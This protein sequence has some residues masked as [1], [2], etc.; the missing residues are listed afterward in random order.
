MQSV[1]VVKG[2]PEMDRRWAVNVTGE[3]SGVAR[4]RRTLT[5]TSE[6]PRRNIAF[7]A[8]TG[9]TIS[10]DGEG[11]YRIGEA[12]RIRIDRDH[13]AQII[14]VADGQQLR[15]PLDI[16]AGESTLVIEYEW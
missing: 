16:A 11:A 14:D 10:S 3:A 7:R 9:E 1:A 5:F 8:A 4:L 2:A 15:L 6:Q 12:L 13:T